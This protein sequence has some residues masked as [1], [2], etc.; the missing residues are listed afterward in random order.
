[1][2]Q[3]LLVLWLVIALLIVREKNIARIIIYLGIFSLLSALCYMLLGSPDVAM[4]EAATSAFTTIFFI[5][6]FEKYFSFTDAQIGSQVIEN[7]LISLKT[8]APLG[9]VV[10]LFAIFVY[11]IPD[12]SGIDSLRNMY[13]SG[14]M[15]DVGGNN[16]VTA[17][18]LGYRVYDTLFEALMVVISVVAVI[19]LSAFSERAPERGSEHSEIEGSRMAVFAIQ[20][21]C[22]VM[23]LFGV[24]LILNGHLTPGGGFQGGLA[25]AAFFICRYMIYDVYDIPIGKLSR[26]EEMVFIGIVLFAI[27][28]IFLGTA[29][30]LPP[31]YLP[32]FQNAYLLLVNALIGLKV[33][34]GFIILFYRYIAVEGE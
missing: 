7:K 15:A 34:C 13:M 4:A 20:I 16:A 6:C 22:P 10:F 26:L 28:V 11:F 32:V 25:A 30:Y 18:Y 33:A 29:A 19:H 3:T 27:S 2:I 14:F 21:I 12:A 17:I 1:M 31:I 8:L 5:I 23:I 24:Y 9:F